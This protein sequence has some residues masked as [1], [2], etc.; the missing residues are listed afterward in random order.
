MN[1]TVQNIDDQGPVTVATEGHITASDTDLSDGNPIA[2][3]LGEDWKT[4]QVLLDMSSTSYIDSSG[5][6]WLIE[7]SRRLK[8]G[9]GGLVV[10]GLQPKVKQV[11]D[12]LRVGRVVSITADH[13]AAEQSL[14]AAS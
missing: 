13:A 2:K 6:G 5:V 14:N 3:V 4:K 9:G 7:T 10:Y 8:E 1:L 12:L 11:L